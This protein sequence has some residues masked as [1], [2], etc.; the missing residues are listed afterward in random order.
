MAER[1]PAL[2]FILHSFAIT[3]L[4]LVTWRRLWLALPSLGVH[5][6]RLDMQ[7]QA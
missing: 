7:N 2:P 4:S 3:G 6:F 1:H 5:K